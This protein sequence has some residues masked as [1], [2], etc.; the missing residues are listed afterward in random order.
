MTSGL[1][2]FAVLDRPY[3]AVTNIPYYLD[4]GGR[5]LFE[6]AWHHD[7]VQHLRYL[8]A[9][10]LAA[11]LRPV[12]QDLSDLVPIDEGL[13]ARLQLV[14]LPPSTSRWRALAELPWTLR[15]LWRAVG[16]AEIVHTGIAGWPYPFG[17]LAN[18]IAKLRG[19]KI[20]MIVESAP[21][22]PTCADTAVSLRKRV[23]AAVYERLGR[24]WCSRADLSFYTQPAYLDCFHDSG[25]GPAFVAPATWVNDE[26]ILDEARARSL[27]DAKMHEP[28]RFLFAGRLVEEKGIGVLL[29]A[30][31]KAA[32]AGVHGALHVIGDGPMRDHV[33]AAQRSGSFSVKYFEPLPYG[34]L[35][36]E[37]LQSHHAVVVPS[38]GDEQ[39]RIV[40]DAAA[41]AVPCLAAATAGLRPHVE[42]GA[43]GRLFPPGDSAALA[44]IM[45][46]WASNTGL[47]RGLAMEALSRVRSKTHRAMH[48]ERSRILVR[49]FGVE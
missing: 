28:V 27:W 37:F 4:A 23:E 40:F 29:E 41:R 5:V 49:C 9:F 47:L 6:R 2:D 18:P 17:W 25:K 15:T 20:L 12:P 45:A 30:V 48:A 35:F 16:R 1:E 33:I 42:D 44:A 11:P 43:S 7:L 31:D 24:W 13:R 39:P 38:L 3:L 34:A 8:P 36:L 26:D 19:K 32:A 10:T 21:W 46:S 14:P 22:R